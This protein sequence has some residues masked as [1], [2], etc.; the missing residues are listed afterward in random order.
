M[1][2]YCI[3][4]I[5]MKES[6]FNKSGWSIVDFEATTDLGKNGRNLTLFHN[7][8]NKYGTG[9]TWMENEQGDYI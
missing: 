5:V 2:F 8:E 4:G 3:N 7:D 6:M 1:K 9:Y